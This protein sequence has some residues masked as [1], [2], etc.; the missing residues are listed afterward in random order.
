ML[1]ILNIL[2]YDFDSGHTT[3]WLMAPLI[4][5]FGCDKVTNSIQ[6]CKG[7]YPFYFVIT[8]NYAKVMLII[9]QWVILEFV[10]V[11][12]LREE[13]NISSINNI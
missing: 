6:S 13:L 12:H 4:I 9:S 10:K 1:V 3:F 5:L 8:Q 7:D 2:L 11:D